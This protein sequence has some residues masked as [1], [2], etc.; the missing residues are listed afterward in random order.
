MPDDLLIKILAQSPLAAAVLAAGYLLRRW[1]E[2]F[3][4]E[5][6]A[7]WREERK[8][9]RAEAADRTQAIKAQADAT[10]DTAK[11]TGRLADALD[12]IN[13]QGLRLDATPFNG[14]AHKP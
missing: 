14:K 8:A 6:W 13:A 10:T 9:D 2:P 11:T 12:K 7:T 4:R 5:L 3:A 1:F